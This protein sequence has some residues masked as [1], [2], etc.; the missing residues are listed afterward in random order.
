MLR[1]KLNQLQPRATDEAEQ[2]IQTVLVLATTRSIFASNKNLASASEPVLDIASAF[3]PVFI[4]GL[5]NTGV[6]RRPQSGDRPA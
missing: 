2:V 3:R 1:H 5:L 6:S 4:Y